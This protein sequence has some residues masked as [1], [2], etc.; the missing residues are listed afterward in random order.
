MS[1]E[2]DRYLKAKGA[3]AFPRAKLRSYV[4]AM[5]ETVIP[6]IERDVAAREQL[7]AELRFATPNV[8]RKIR[9]SE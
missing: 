6:Q 8:A 5:T 7:A 1:T 3:R 2:L 9:G 4:T